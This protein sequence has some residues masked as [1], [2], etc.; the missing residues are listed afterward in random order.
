[1]TEQEAKSKL[2]DYLYNE[3]EVDQRKEFE[4]ILS[5]NPGL[6]QDLLELKSTRE[7]LQSE[8]G[9]VPHKNLLLI[10]PN[11][12]TTDK[13]R[14][15]RSKNKL[16]YLKTAAA[17]AATILLTV[18]AFSFVNL[19]I[20]QTDQGLLISFGEQ[21]AASIQSQPEPQISEEEL[22]GLVT[23]LQ[24]ENNRVIANVIEQT[25]QEHQQQLADVIQTLTAYYD[26]RRQQDLI[27]ISEGLAQLEEET[28]YR[29]LQTE[30]ALE[31]LIFALSYQQTEE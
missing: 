27:L 6:Q 4:K 23:E 10:P 19:Q 22:Y 16:Y 15:D 11:P 24:E 26:Q 1:M 28:Y 5:K 7:L 18:I 2:M 30:E 29:F 17:F 8:P 14:S 20:N 31:D 9:E 12:E 13:G 21:P 3:M 25:R